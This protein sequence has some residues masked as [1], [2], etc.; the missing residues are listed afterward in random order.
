[1]R[2]MAPTAAELDGSAGDMLVLAGTDPA[3]HGDWVL[4]ATERSP[5]DALD[6]RAPRPVLESVYR[7]G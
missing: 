4:V 2:V 5:A 3:P 1:M 7:M 6:A